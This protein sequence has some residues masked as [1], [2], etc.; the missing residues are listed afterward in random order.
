M[1]SPPVRFSCYQDRVL[2]EMPL[3]DMRVFLSS[4]YLD[5]AEHRRAATEAIQRLGAQADRMEIFGARPEEPTTACLDEIEHAD[6]FVGIYAH[7][8]GFVP[9]DSNE[10]VTER[11]FRHANSLKKPLFC[12]LVEDGH[13]WPPN[14]IEGGTGQQKLGD[15]KRRIQ[16]TTTRDTFTSPADLAYKIAT[17]LG[18][19]LSQS[20]SGTPSKREPD[21]IYVSEL[22]QARSFEELLTLTVRL[23]EKETLTDY[24][25]IFLTSVS[26]YG[27]HLIAVADVI[28]GFK[29]RYRVAALGGILGRCFQTGEVANV[30]DVRTRPGYFQAVPATRSELVVPIRSQKAVVGVLN[31]ESEERDHYTAQRQTSAVAIAD[32]L[33]ASLPEFGW[34]PGRAADDLPWIRLDPTQRA[35]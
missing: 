17:S 20:A 16:E 30:G 7:R 1:K 32:A 14:M 11:E 15:L 27:Q 6:V 25:Q 33:G 22:Q 13:P 19:Y 21:R 24:N 34:S 28:S 29:Q 23:L 35:G 2:S 10:S 5:L 31:S 12:F 8:Y 4:T 26:A 18:R 9:S 3:L